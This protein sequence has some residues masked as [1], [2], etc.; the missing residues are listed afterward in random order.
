MEVADPPG[1]DRKCLHD[2]WV[3]LT[4]SPGDLRR[5]NPE[6]DRFFVVEPTVNAELNL[7]SFMRLDI[8]AGYRVVSGVSEWGYSNS[9]VSGAS[10]SATL[11]FGKF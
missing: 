8:G 11:K 1:R 10:A 9:D 4:G 2:L 6:P 7:M 5:A 3:G